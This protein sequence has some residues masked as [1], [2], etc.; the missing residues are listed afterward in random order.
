MSLSPDS[1]IFSPL[2]KYNC[3]SANYST[4]R[5]SGKF[6]DSFTDFDVDFLPPGESG[7]HFFLSISSIHTCAYIYISIHISIHL[8][9]YLFLHPSLI[10][11]LLICI[12]SALSPHLFSLFI[13]HTVSHSSLR[14]LHLNRFFLFIFFPILSESCH[15]GDPKSTQLAFASQ[16]KFKRT[17]RMQRTF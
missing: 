17:F 3:S 9:I 1:E 11:Y 15:H 14:T 2:P 10:I 6:D 8:S 16:R 4:T 12:T 7:L 13:S 5:K